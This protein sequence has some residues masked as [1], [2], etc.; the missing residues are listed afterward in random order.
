[1]YSRVELRRVQYSTVQDRTVE[2]SRVYSALCNLLKRN[3][4]ISSTAYISEV[5]VIHSSTVKC[6]AEYDSKSSRSVVEY[7]IKWNHCAFCFNGIE[8]KLCIRISNKIKNH[9][10]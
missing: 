10:I 6:S 1:V 9:T 2:W 4:K 5:N 3:M 7:S 8:Q